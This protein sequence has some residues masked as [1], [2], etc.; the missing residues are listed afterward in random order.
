M[1]LKLILII[2]KSKVLNYGLLLNKRMEGEYI[3]TVLK[4]VKELKLV[5]TPIKEGILESILVMVRKLKN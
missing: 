5:L 2:I 4:E 1:I 3:K